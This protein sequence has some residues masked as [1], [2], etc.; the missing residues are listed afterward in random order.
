MAEGED[1]VICKIKSKT[2]W[3]LVETKEDSPDPLSPVQ[4][5]FG[6]EE[7]SKRGR[8]WM[9]KRGRKEN[10]KYI[11]QFSQVGTVKFTTLILDSQI[12]PRLAGYWRQIWKKTGAVLSSTDRNRVDSG[13][14]SRWYF[15]F[16][17][18][19]AS[20]NSLADT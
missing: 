10:A 1:M 6:K 11:S 2:V 19:G 15:F 9:G 12:L 4:T 7:K 3:S 14:Q 20:H 16:W 13:V 18:C 8:Q 5:H 17:P